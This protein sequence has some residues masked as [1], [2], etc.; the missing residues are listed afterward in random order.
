V[1]RPA[2][3]PNLC[4]GLE[5]YQDDDFILRNGEV[6]Q[7]MVKS[8]LELLSQDCLDTTE[9]LLKLVTY[10]RAEILK[11]HNRLSAIPTAPEIAKNPMLMQKERTSRMFGSGEA[12]F[13]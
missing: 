11:L 4:C 10:Y 1:A 7:E 6:L 9:C 3:A 2:K 13:R 8:D 12:R 5:E